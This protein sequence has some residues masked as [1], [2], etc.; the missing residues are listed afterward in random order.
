MTVSYG[1]RSSN[2]RG[3]EHD[4]VSLCALFCRAL[5]GAADLLWALLSLMRG[6]R[7]DKATLP[8][9]H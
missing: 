8:G 5:T 1:S 7:P 6:T 9:L 3:K 4:G 2:G